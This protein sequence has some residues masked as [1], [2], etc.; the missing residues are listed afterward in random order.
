MAK[1]QKSTHNFLFVMFV[2]LTYFNSLVRIHVYPRF[3]LFYTFIFVFGN[4]SFFLSNT[5]C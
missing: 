5:G 2:Y 4:L 3:A 1:F